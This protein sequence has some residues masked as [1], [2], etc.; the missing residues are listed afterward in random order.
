MSGETDKWPSRVVDGLDQGWHL[1]G[2][3]GYPLVYE[4][5][6]GFQRDLTTVASLDELTAG[7]GPL[8]PV[9]AP[10]DAEVAEIERLLGMAG[11]RAVL[12]LA[13]GIEVVVHEHRTTLMTAGMS[14]PESY[15][16][17]MRS[18]LA[19]RE[20]SWEAGLLKD[21]VLI[22]NGH[23]LVKT[24][25]RE[26]QSVDEM[27]AAGPD[28]RVNVEARDGFTAVVRVW[29]R[30]EDRYVEVAETL[31]AL[32]SHWAD[33]KHGQKG[34]RA[35]ADQWLQP[36]ARIPS[37]ELGPLYRLFYSRSAHYNVEVH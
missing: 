34:W 12:S 32:V 6:Y 37:D 25:G 10:T 30:S 11:R 22:G 9:E 31:A 19:G 4:A 3:G 35:I 5:D 16:P 7:R 21:A 13:A 36:E 18:V 8:K 24:T 20:G 28:R 17:S 1:S 27:R 15:E 2:G 29:T 33:E 23:N 14:V 26:Y